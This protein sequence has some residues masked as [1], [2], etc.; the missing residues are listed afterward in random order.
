MDVLYFIVLPPQL[1]LDLFFP[2]VLCRSHFVFYV[3]HLSAFSL[4]RLLPV[5]PGK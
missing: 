3:F 2:P 1:M 5:F 4:L